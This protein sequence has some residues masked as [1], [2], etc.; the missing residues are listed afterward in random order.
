[1]RA[2]LGLALAAVLGCSHET[3]PTVQPDDHPPLP[4]ASGTPIGYLID[5]ASELS[6][7]D[8]QLTQLKEI[9]TELADKLAVLDGGQRGGKPAGDAT[10]SQTGRHRGGRRGGMGG[11]G[12]GGAGGG[13]G[14]AGGGMGGRGGRGRRSAQ[15]A[16][17]GSGSAS[18]G[19]NAAAGAVNERAAD[20]HDALRRAFALLDPHQ[21]EVATRVLSDR[22]VDVDTDHPGEDAEEPAAGSDEK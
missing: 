13:M 7:R 3:K 19:G 20:V 16:G 15:G 22:G 4:S 5:D 6:L 21:K 2:V 17:A 8:D 9:D 11:G 1:M 12:T 18:A 10:G 14:G